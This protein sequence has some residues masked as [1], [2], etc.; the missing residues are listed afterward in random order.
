MGPCLSPLSLG[1]REPVAFALL[2]VVDVH[3]LG[4]AKCVEPF[5]A[6]LAADAALAYAAER[7][8][9]V[10]RERVIHPECARLDLLHRRLTERRVVR[11]EVAATPASPAVA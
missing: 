4:L 9:L 7:A 5:F 2:D 10:V 11:E 8:S 1:V 3:V 6:Q